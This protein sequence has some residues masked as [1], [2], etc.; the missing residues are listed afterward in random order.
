V[1]RVKATPL[2]DPTLT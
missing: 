2:R 1:Q